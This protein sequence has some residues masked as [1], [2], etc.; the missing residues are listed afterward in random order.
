MPIKYTGAMMVNR[1]RVR[2]YSEINPAIV[3]YFTRK[4]WSKRA[5]HKLN[6][7]SKTDCTITAHVNGVLVIEKT[8][9][10]RAIGGETCTR[11]AQTSGKSR[12]GNNNGGR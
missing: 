8:V 10:A 12:C 6:V 7:T 5:R 9:G 4:K 11:M 1:E 2:A 3:G